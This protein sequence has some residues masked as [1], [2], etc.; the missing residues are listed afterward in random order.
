MT[1]ALFVVLT[2][3]QLAFAGFILFLCVAFVT[4]GPFVPSNK[5]SVRAMITLARL[6]PGQT[7]ID[8]GSGDGRVLFHAAKKGV[9]AIGIEINPYLVLYTRFRAFLGPYR[10]NITVLWKNLWNADLK[11]ANVVFVYLIPWKMDVLAKKLREETKPGTLIVSNTF[12]FPHWKIVRKDVKHH[13]Y[14][15]TITGQK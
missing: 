8:V 9:K 10:G 6:H 2:A 4:G 5:N 12:I 3:L 14:A 15:F 13:I 7:V 11:D 1:L